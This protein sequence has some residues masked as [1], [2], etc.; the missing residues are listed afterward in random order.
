MSGERILIVDD[1]RLIRYSL[2]ERLKKEGFVCE[3]AV[4]GTS[5][6]GR[7]AEGDIDLVLLDYRLPDTD[8]LTVLRRI[9]EELPETP[10]ILMTAYSTV[11][12]AVEAMKLGAFHYLNKPFNMDE[13]VLLTRKAL[14]TT[15]LKGE[16]RRMRSHE[17]DA[18]GTRR[19]IGESPAMKEVLRILEKVIPSNATVLLQGESGTGKDLMARFIHYRSERAEAPFMT[20]TCS[21]LPEML[22]ESELFGHERG[23]FTDA[24]F[25]KKGLFELAHLGTLFLDEIGDLPVNLQSKLLRFLEERTFKRV[26]GTRD[27]RV[28]VRIVAATN[29]DLERGVRE[30]RFRE[31]LY[32][33]I[34]VIP[35]YLPP[36][37]ERQEDLPL[38]ATHLIE[39]L[40]R[41]FKRKVLGVSPEAMKKLAEYTWPGNVRELRNVLERAMILGVDEWLREPDFL[42]EGERRAAAG[43]AFQ[44][45]PGGVNFEEVER[46]LVEQALK[47]AR[48]NQSNAARLLGMTRDQIRYRMEKF[49]LLPARGGGEAGGGS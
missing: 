8:G 16:V 39:Q 49:Q 12:H 41:E 34:K 10:V 32:F 29:R 9:V 2:S 25:Q 23:A 33:R 5:A 20:V 45:P 44:L 19:V 28:D 15:R 43:E 4:D 1:E 22:L 35:I 42:L 6:V 14:E 40:N 47:R 24:R 31:D 3:E 18:A 37:R 7:L 48:G 38:L 13:V 17:R 27:I 26:G 30:G 36:L 46:N 11:E 21:T